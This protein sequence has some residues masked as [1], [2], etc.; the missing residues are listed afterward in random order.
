MQGLIIIDVAWCVKLLTF[1][2]EEFFE[3]SELD[4]HFELFVL[5]ELLLLELAWGVAVLDLES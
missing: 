4:E 5:F 2:L 1:P 3:L